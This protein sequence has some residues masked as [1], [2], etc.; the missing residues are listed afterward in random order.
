MLALEVAEEATFGAV[1]PL[2][3]A[4]VDHEPAVTA[5]GNH[6]SID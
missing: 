1:V 6:W 2:R 5:L 3:V 4:S